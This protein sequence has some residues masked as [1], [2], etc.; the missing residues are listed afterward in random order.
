MESNLWVVVQS[1]SQV[2]KDT[3][4]FVNKTKSSAV[5]FN[6]TKEEV[7]MLVDYGYCLLDYK[8]WYKDYGNY[9]VGDLFTDYYGKQ[10]IIQRINLSTT[11]DG[12]NYYETHY[13][14]NDKLVEVGLI[15]GNWGECIID[16][17]KFI[18]NRPEL[19]KEN[20]VETISLFDN[21]ELSKCDT[22]DCEE[23]E[24]DG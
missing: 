10:F 6:Y 3:V 21:E 16:M 1:K 17:A 15:G 20:K 12:M 22:V 4:K 13:V 2:G 18:G 14:E 5:A 24:V 23:Q 19:L 8:L 11:P 7:D 9:K